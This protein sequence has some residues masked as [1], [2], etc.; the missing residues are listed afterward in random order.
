MYAQYIYAGVS[1]VHYAAVLRI[2][3]V[4]ETKLTSIRRTNTTYT[5]KSYALLYDKE[6]H[7]IYSTFYAIC[8]HNYARIRR[9]RAR[10]IC[11]RK[12]EPLFQQCTRKHERTNE[13]TFSLIS[14]KYYKLGTEH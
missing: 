2:E 9:S 4:N 1:I 10:I 3:L 5:R 12:Y 7:Y 14:I 6:A 8:I 13:R 11:E